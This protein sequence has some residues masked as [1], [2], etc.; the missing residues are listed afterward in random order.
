M[1]A[2]VD[3]PAE[4]RP[5]DRRVRVRWWLEGAIAV[6][7]ALVGALLVDLAIL[8]AVLADPPPRGL[9][10]AAVGVAG[11]ALAAGVPVVRYRRWRYAV[12]PEDLWLQ[13]GV[14]VERVTVIP[15][16]RLQFVDTRQGPLDRALGLA[17]LVVHTA[18][19]GTAGTVP[20]LDVAEAAR[21][22]ER[23]ARVDPDAP[24]V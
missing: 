21:L 5:L 13:S 2:P 7:G 19:I 8:P 14:L 12:R 3:V 23:L 11:S 16:S 15:L 1:S 24:G 4:L 17:Q 9:L 18:A 20:G 6:S 10:S 22:R